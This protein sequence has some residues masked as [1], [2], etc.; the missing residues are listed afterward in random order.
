MFPHSIRRPPRSW[1][2]VMVSQKL[3][4]LIRPGGGEAL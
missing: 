1:P 2:L 4:G 3:D